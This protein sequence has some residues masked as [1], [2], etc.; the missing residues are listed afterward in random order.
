MKFQIFEDKG[1][2]WRW[3]AQAG[4]NIL[5]SSGEGFE[6]PQK[7][8]AALRKNIVRGDEKLEKNLVKAL[9]DAGL[10]EKGGKV[11]ALAA[12][13]VSIAAKPSKEKRVKVAL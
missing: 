3:N 9:K 5:F 7:A 10:D 11:K 6:K 12:D 13:K 8:I 4:G 2:E 1:G